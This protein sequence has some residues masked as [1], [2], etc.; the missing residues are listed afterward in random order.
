[1][2]ANIVNAIKQNNHKLA[3]DLI[4]QTQ[5]V[6]ERVDSDLNT[7]LHIAA[8]YGFADGIKA[9]LS[10]EDTVIM[11]NSARKEPFEVALIKK[12]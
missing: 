9:L 11:M 8:E 6:N 3:L 4:K 5:N 10:K 1:M 12:K 2:N 7:L